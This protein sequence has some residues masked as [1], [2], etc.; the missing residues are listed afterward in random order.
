MSQLSSPKRNYDISEQ[1]DRPAVAKMCKSR[2]L[3]LGK[4][5]SAHS[6]T[7]NA[8]S[9][10]ITRP[11]IQAYIISAARGAWQESTLY[12]WV[13]VYQSDFSAFEWRVYI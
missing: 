11:L 7:P 6:A 12:A 2:I 1:K 3:L 5:P 8:N 4:Q 13:W 10:I 9:D